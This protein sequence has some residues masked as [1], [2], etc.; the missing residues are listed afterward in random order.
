MRPH[1]QAAIGVALSLP[2]WSDPQ[3]ARLLGGGKTNLNVLLSDQGRSFVVRLGKDIPEHGVMRWNELA[4]SRAAHAADLAPAVHYT[5]AGVLVLDYVE[6]T[7]LDEAGVRDPANMLRI[8][9]LV[10]RV[11]RDT[12]AHLRGPVLAFW[13]YARPPAVQ[14]TLTS[15]LGSDRLDVH[16]QHR[17][18]DH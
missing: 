11:H 12:M 2:C 16:C 1:E 18:F 5:G 9:D 13:V 10:A 17:A 14:G 7:P 8:V 6:A 3:E 4:V 15:S